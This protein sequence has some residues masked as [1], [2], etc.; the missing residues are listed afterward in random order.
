MTDTASLPRGVRNNNP[1]NIR[2]SKPSIPWRG[3]AANQNDEEFLVFDSPEWGLRAIA[4]ILL[5][6]QAEGLAT[7]RQMIG[8]WAPS[9]ENDTEA[10]VRAV[11][12]EM[13]VGANEPLDLAN[14]PLQLRFFVEAIVHQENGQQPY[15]T[16]QLVRGVALAR[17]A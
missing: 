6:Y 16:D 17:A 2:R 4:K 8:H 10:Y 12:G 15:S 1:G 7:V 11:A 9:V 3:L 5:H 13:G 14:R